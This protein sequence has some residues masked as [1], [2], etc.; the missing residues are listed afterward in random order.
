MKSQPKAAGQAASKLISEK[1]A[2]LGDWRGATLARMRALITDADPDVLD[3]VLEG[4]GL[5][6]FQG[7]LDLIH[8]G[9]ARALHRFGDVD[10]GV[11]SGAAPDLIGIHGRVQR[12]ELQIGIAEPVAEFGDLRLI[13]IIEVLATAEDFHCG[14]SGLLNSAEQGR[15]QPVIDEQM[16]GEYV[17]HRVFSS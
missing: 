13:A 11:R 17:I 5:G 9:Q 12:V 4:D 10:D 8:H 7:A 6:D 14:D 16:G 2:E 1:I 15:R 3:E